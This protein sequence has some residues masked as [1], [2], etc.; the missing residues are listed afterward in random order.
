MTECKVM[1]MKLDSSLVRQEREK[2]AWS[3][4]HLAQVT[5]LALRTIQRIESTGSASYESANAIAAVFVLPVA[6][7]RIDGATVSSGRAAPW[8]AWHQLMTLLGCGLLAAVFTPPNLRVTIPAAVIFWLSCE[9]AIKT[10]HAR[11]A[12]T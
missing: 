2:R 7:L 4:E 6:T 5:G 1:D 11:R 3:Q 9:L 10:R 8:L 12:R